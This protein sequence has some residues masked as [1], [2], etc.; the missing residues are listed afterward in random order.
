MRQF[1]AAGHFSD[2]S[3]FDVTS[4]AVWSSTNSQVASVNAPVSP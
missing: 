2:G 4:L 1:A 3:S